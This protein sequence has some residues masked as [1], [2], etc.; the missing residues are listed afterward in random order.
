[1]LG[2]FCFV[3]YHASNNRESLRKR[4]LFRAQTFLLKFSHWPVLRWS[5]SW[6][7]SRFTVK[8]TPYMVTCLRGVSDTELSAGDR[9]P[10]R[11]FTSIYSYDGAKLAQ[12]EDSTSGSCFQVKAHVT[13]VTATQNRRLTR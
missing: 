6:K 7:R 12:T 8:K 11:N 4:L 2:F 3:F 1:M 10:A 13:V 9:F 5:P